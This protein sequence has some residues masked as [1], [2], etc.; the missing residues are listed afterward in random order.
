M[1]TLDASPWVL[2]ITQARIDLCA[3]PIGRMRFTDVDEEEGHFVFVALIDF[4]K[5]TY[6]VPKR[7]SG[8]RTENQGDGPI[9]PEVA[10]PDL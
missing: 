7:R 3:P 10:E 4:V 9:A 6:L 5:G 1:E 2:D 8:V